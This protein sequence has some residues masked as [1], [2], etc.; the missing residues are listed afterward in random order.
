MTA[1]GVGESPVDAP[2]PTSPRAQGSIWTPRRTHRQEDTVTDART[3]LEAVGARLRAV[4]DD[5]Q[6][7]PRDL[8]AVAREYRMYL[9]TLADNKPRPQSS[10]LDEIA[11][12]RVKRGAR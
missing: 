9:A 4:L 10:P 5:P 11:A 8:A 2:G 3:D 6:T 7:S 12:R 1:S